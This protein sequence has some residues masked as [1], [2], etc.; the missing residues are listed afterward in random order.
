M[1]IAITDDAVIPRREK[2]QK[3]KKTYM[4]LSTGSKNAFSPSSVVEYARFPTK[5]CREERD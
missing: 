4:S 2:I 1:S 3:G 5:T